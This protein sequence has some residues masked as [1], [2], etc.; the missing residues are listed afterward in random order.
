MLEAIAQLVRKLPEVKEGEEY[1]KKI[2]MSKVERKVR[3]WKNYIIEILDKE[4]YR[5]FIPGKDQEDL[6]AFQR[7]VIKAFI[8]HYIIPKQEK[9]GHLSFYGI[10][11]K[12]KP[13]N[14]SLDELKEKESKLWVWLKENYNYIIENKRKKKIT[15]KI[16]RIPVPQPQDVEEELQKELSMK[17][18]KGE[19]LICLNNKELTPSERLS[20][21]FGWL[22]KAD[23]NIA[24][25]YLHSGKWYEKSIRICTDCVKKLETNKHFISLEDTN[26]K[27]PNWRI[28]IFPYFENEEEYDVCKFWEDIN[29]EDNLDSI[30]ENY[31]I[32]QMESISERIFLTLVFFRQEKNKQD[33]VMEKTKLSN[34]IQAYKIFKKWKESEKIENIKLFAKKSLLSYLKNKEIKNESFF[35][36]VV[37]KIIRL[38]RIDS[39]METRLLSIFN[40]ITQKNILDYN[41]KEIRN[42]ISAIKFIQYYNKHL[43]C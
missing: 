40:K 37:K 16:L 1:I 4:P 7:E 25:I 26:L 41:L 32:P 29:R 11:E 12:K 42:K 10:K 2:M 39:T 28:K 22:I 6:H 43:L 34:L 18:E 3:N 5:F 14:L 13:Q 17:K 30:I 31:I 9:R 23:K 20:K 24:P 19:C 36:D 38:E 33:I 35:L 8:E 27:L 15:I 21:I